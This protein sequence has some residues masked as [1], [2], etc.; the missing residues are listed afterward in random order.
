MTA[1]PAELQAV[2]AALAD[3]TRRELLVHLATDGSGT[4]TRLAADLPIT[5]QAV[6]KHLATL[7]EA[8]LVAERRAGKE[9][10]YSVALE[11]L[12]DAAGWMAAVGARWDRRLAALERYLT[13]PDEGHDGAAEVEG[14]HADDSRRSTTPPR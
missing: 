5:R 14:S 13:E 11:P 7:A 6:A 4:T 9:R 12:E 1:P 2:F 8:G 10:R 3:P